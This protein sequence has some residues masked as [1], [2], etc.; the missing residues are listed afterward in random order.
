LLDVGGEEFIIDLLF[1]RLKLRC[2][3]VVELKA[4]KF[5]PEHLGQLGFYL[6]AVDR[7]VRNEHDNPIIGLLLC[8]SRNKVVT[9][10]ALG[11]KSQPM[12]VVEYKLAQS[13]P[14]ELQTSLP[15]IERIK[16]ELA[17]LDDQGNHRN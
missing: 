16:R 12:G 1:Y 13:L 7:K 5:K 17:G 10:Y 9:E 15:S 11:D 4:G 8:K 3:V 14:A 6:A 2:Y